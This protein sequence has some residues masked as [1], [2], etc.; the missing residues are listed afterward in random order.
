MGTTS[1]GESRRE[2]LI[3]RHTTQKTSAPRLNGG[4][5]RREAGVDAANLHSSDASYSRT[6]R[7][8]LRV[9]HILYGHPEKTHMRGATWAHESAADNV[10]EFHHQLAQTLSCRCSSLS[11][12]A[13]TASKCSRTSYSKLWRINLIKCLGR[14]SGC[15]DDIAH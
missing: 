14:C 3:V 1:W 8:L 9:A 4:G 7:V 6:F 10:D 15:G 2:T 12:A 13:S 11:T 5:E